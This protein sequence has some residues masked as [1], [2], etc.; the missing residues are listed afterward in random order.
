MCH[1]SCLQQQPAAQLL[2]AE[3]KTSECHRSLSGNFSKFSSAVLLISRMLS[4][5][6]GNF[7]KS[8][9]FKQFSPITLYLQKGK[10]WYNCEQTEKV[11]SAYVGDYLKI[12]REVNEN[13]SQEAKSDISLH[14]K[15]AKSI[16]SIFR[17]VPCAETENMTIM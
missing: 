8:R 9:L 1:V 17:Y 15:T 12:C 7:L 3:C 5:Q 2:H 13:Y 11:N 16:Y 6:T 4:T 10:N 14:S